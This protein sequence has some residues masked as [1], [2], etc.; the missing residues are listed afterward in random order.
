[1]QGS[2]C[3]VKN[4]NNKLKETNMKIK[5]IVLIVLILILSDLIANSQI[6]GDKSKYYNYGSRFFAEMHLM[7]SDSPDSV[8]SALMIKI[9]YSTLN[10]VKPQGVVSVKDVFA[11]YPYVEAEIKDSQGIIR[12]LIEWRD[13][14]E[15]NDYNSTLARDIYMNGLAETTLINDDYSAIVKLYDQNMS[16]VKEIKIPTIKKTE[17]YTKVSMTDPIL[18]KRSDSDIEEKDLFVP[19]VFENRIPLSDDSPALL[20]SVSYDDDFPSYDY[21]IKLDSEDITG[22]EWKNP[23]ELKGRITPLEDVELNHREINKDGLIY[24][25][26]QKNDSS[27]SM[28]SGVLAI[29]FP[30]EN[31]VPGTY[32]LTL[33][34]T[35]TTDTL[36]R[37]FKVKWMEMPLSLYNYKYAAEMMYYILTEE[38]LDKLDDG[39]EEELR[40][41]LW[42]YWIDHDPTP[43]TLYNEAMEAYFDRVDYAYYNFKTFN[44]AD[45]AKTARGKIYILKGEP[46]EILRN[47]NDGIITERWIYPNLKQEFVFTTENN[48]NYDLKEINDI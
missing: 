43:S 19:Y 39:S 14:V 3:N 40:L 45:G 48:S 5:N 10:F 35:N 34:K 23:T 12:K 16:L 6:P 46:K 28:R 44:Q 7:P 27:N 9:S 29:D 1:M 18:C 41:K 47:I 42:Y 38:E 17:F 24:T 4:Y 25:I 26:S 37:S 20:V 30:K 36:T 13:T 8:K 22:L 32:T 15:T 11:A 31:L 33:T 21:K 2:I